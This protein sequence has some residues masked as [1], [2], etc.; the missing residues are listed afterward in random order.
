MTFFDDIKLVNFEPTIQTFD[1]QGENQSLA[2]ILKWGSDY[3]QLINEGA[4]VYWCVNPQVDSFPPE[5]GIKLTREIC[6]IGLDSDVCKEK[7]R[8]E[9]GG[10]LTQDDVD[11]LKLK[12]FNRLVELEIPPTGILESKNGLQPYFLFEPIELP[13]VPD[14][15][16]MNLVYRNIVS[17][18]KK[19]DDIPSEADSI[20]RVLRLEGT[21]HQK[22]IFDTFEIKYIGGTGKIVSFDKLKSRYY[23]EN[24]A[25]KQ[26]TYIKKEAKAGS[27]YAA[28]VIDG[29]MRLSGTSLVCGEKYDFEDE[30][31]GKRQIIIDGRRSGQ[32][33]DV[34]NNTIGGHPGGDGSTNLV[35][36]VKYYNENMSEDEIRKELDEIVMDKPKQVRVIIPESETSEVKKIKSGLDVIDVSIPYFRS[37][38]TY[39]VGGY[40]KSGKSTLCLNI[41]EKL[42]EGGLKVGIIDTEQTKLDVVNVLAMMTRN[43]TFEEMENNP[44]VAQEWIVENKTRF[45]YAG[46]KDLLDEKSQLSWN[47]TVDVA[48]K[49]I[50]NG[51]DVLVFDNLT[52]YSATGAEGGWNVLANALM[53][54]I[55]LSRKHNILCFVVIHIKGDAVISDKPE[56]VKK[57]IKTDPMAIFQSSFS[58]LRRPSGKD[59]YG[60]GAARSQLSGTLLVWRPYQMMNS[61]ILR[62]NGMIIF[63]NFSKTSPLGDVRVLYDGAHRKFIYLSLNKLK[64]EEK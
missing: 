23:Q 63:E 31:S 42:I 49:M 28:D 38:G 56:W 14:R 25:P 41:A 2:R 22:N 24:E 33:I 15:M 50:E 21:L 18:M 48:T 29:L 57:V 58:V 7:Q 20:A 26:I 11:D 64:M 16:E 3:K 35:R 6:C 27:I 47:K 32:W 45:E 13:T 43:K 36:W 62:E 8:Q 5:R 53:T 40:E 51:A 1:D 60:G 54:V 59:L 34:A 44:V 55:N 37:P 4:G 10:D 19:I 17:G 52:T 46:I 12:L 30:R 9:N 61:Q 39:V